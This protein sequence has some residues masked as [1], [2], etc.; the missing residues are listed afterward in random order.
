MS[1]TDAERLD[2]LSDLM[3]KAAQGSPDWRDDDK[4][5]LMLDCDEGDGARVTGI[6]GVKNVPAL[7]EM[8]SGQL[9]GI[10]EEMTGGT[11]RVTTF[12]LQ[13]PPPIS[14]N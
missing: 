12:Q 7:T 5:I 3:L 13:R 1:S 2:R 14:P 4:I 6:R 10:I 8:V 11:V 9:E